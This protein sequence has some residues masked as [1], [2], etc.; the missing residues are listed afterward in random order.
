MEFT[1]REVQ[2][3]KRAERR[4]KQ[5]AVV[6][7]LAILFL[8]AQIALFFL[9]QLGS[10]ALALSAFALV[11]LAVLVPQLGGAPR[12]EQLVSLLASKLHGSERR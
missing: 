6:R 11:L 8:L 5:A 1:Q 4:I 9:G 3:I 10:D 2:I 12:Y 7:V